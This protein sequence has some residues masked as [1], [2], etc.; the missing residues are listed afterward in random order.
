MVYH[1]LPWF[2]MAYHGLPWFT[3]VYHG[4]CMVYQGLPWFTVQTRILTNKFVRSSF[5]VCF[6]LSTHAWFDVELNYSI[7]QTQQGHVHPP[8][9]LQPQYQ[10]GEDNYGGAATPHTNIENNKRFPS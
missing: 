3:L 4:L 2:T 10:E 5:F 1:V 7:Q 6:F 8:H 9:H